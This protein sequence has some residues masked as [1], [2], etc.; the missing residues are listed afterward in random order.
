MSQ[1]IS[2][3]R[4]GNARKNSYPRTYNIYV[5]GVN[6]YGWYKICLDYLAYLLQCGTRALRTLICFL[7]TSRCNGYLL[8]TTN[9]ENE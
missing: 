4:I 6:G 3:Y 2:W 5:W 9:Y 8:A 7:W 1:F